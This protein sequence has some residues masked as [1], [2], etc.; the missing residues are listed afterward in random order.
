MRSHEKLGMTTHLI[1]CK[2]PQGYVAS[3][4]RSQHDSVRLLAGSWANKTREAVETRKGHRNGN[5]ILFA[6]FFWCVCARLNQER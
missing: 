2:C 5:A 3:A 1:C 4:L 6:L